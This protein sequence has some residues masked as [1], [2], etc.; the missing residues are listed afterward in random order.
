MFYFFNLLFNFIFKSYMDLTLREQ[1]NLSNFQIWK[2]NTLQISNGYNLINHPLLIT[3]VG[4]S[5]Y[6]YIDTNF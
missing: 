6:T 3:M 1:F 2:Y 5:K 4:N